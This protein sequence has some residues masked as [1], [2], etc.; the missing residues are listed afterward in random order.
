VL[1]SGAFVVTERPS[2]Y[3]RQLCEHFAHEKGRHGAPEVE[4]TFDEYEGFVDFAHVISGTCRL[5]ARQQGALVLSARGTNQAALERVQGVLT[6][7]VERF[8]RRDGLTVDW[9]PASEVASS[10]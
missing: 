6:D 10:D 8:G 2:H 4:V 7:H 5:D 1:A 9:G 3:L